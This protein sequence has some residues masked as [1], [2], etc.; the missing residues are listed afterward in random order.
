MM[1][2]EKRLTQ[3]FELDLNDPDFFEKVGNVYSLNK[4]LSVKPWWPPLVEVWYCQGVM[5]DDYKSGS[6]AKMAWPEAWKMLQELHASYLE[7]KNA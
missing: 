7:A 6:A 3:L 2:T 1:K 4:E 5:P